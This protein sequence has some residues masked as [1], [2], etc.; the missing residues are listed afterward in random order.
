MEKQAFKQSLKDKTIILVADRTYKKSS[1]MDLTGNNLE[2]IDDEYFHEISSGLAEISGKVIHCQNPAEL[3]ELR[4]DPRSHIVFTVYGGTSS[5]NRMAL[6]PSVCEGKGLPYAGANPY[7]RIVCQ[8]KWV[9]KIF[10][11]RYNVPSPSGIVIRERLRPELL[12]ELSVPIMIKPN[13]EGSSIGISGDSRAETV[14][15]AVEQ[16]KKLGASFCSIIAEEFIAGKEVCLCMVGNAPRFSMFKM[17]EVYDPSDEAFFMNRPYSA[18]HK[19][20]SYE[21]FLHRD[22]TELLGPQDKI[23]IQN[24]MGGFS[25]MDYMRIDGRLTEKG[26][27]MIEL[28]PDAHLGKDSVMAAAAFAN[29]MSYEDLLFEIIYASQNGL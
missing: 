8:D 17:M 25:K 21:R 26:F 6:V 7:A 18:E 23:A 2:M 29:G 22:I 20:K 19:H 16:I 12:E 4:A 15:Q 14:S 10:A 3:I 27:V 9:S 1:E 24:M 11:E 13:L 28:T 5:R